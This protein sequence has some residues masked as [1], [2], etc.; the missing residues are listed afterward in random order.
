[1]ARGSPDYDPAMQLGGPVGDRNQAML[2]VLR[3]D[4]RQ[5]WD[6]ERERSRNE[7]QAE[8]AEIGMTMPA[9]WDPLEDY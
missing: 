1:M 6:A 7:A 5:A 2:T 9:G 8:M 3:P 4:K